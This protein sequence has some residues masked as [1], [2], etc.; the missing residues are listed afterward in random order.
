VPLAAC[1]QRG[2]RFWIG[3]KQFQNLQEVKLTG[4]SHSL[5]ATT[6]AQLAKDI[7]EMFFDS[8]D[9]QE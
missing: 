9:S 5:G 3:E 7:V 4:A 8:A 1:L 6:H 2:L